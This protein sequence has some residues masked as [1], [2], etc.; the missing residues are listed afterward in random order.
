MSLSPRVAPMLTERAYGLW[1]L[2]LAVM[3]LAWPASAAEPAAGA[4]A[5][6]V[7]EVIFVE[8]AATAQLPGAPPRFLQKGEPLFQGETLNTGGQ[9]FAIIGF[10]DGTKM[11]LRANTTFTIER[12]RHGGTDDS[13]GFRLIKGGLRAVTGL[14][15]KR[16]PKAMQLNAVNATI[17]IRGTTFD[18][19]ICDEECVQEQRRSGDKP[20]VVKEDLVVA[21]AAVV[22][23]SAQAI[24]PAGEARPLAVGSALFTGDTV[25]TQNASQVLIAFRDRSKVTVVANSQFKLENVQFGPKGESGNFV[26]RVLQGGVRALT[27]ILAKNNPKAVNFNVTTV[28][29]GIRGS[30]FDG[31]IGTVCVADGKCGEGVGASVREDGIDMTHGDQTL[32]LGL[33]ESGVLFNNLLVRVPNIHIIFPDVG[34]MLPENTPVDFEA[35]FSSLNIEQLRRGFYI[36]LQGEQGELEF[37][38]RNNTIYLSGGQGAVLPEGEDTVFRTLQNWAVE[39]NRPVVNPTVN[40]AQF[41]GSLIREDKVICEIR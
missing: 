5:K 40:P 23:G 18:A 13:A 29:I 39:L 33:G 28:V 38:A 25:R 27:G 32:T 24:N 4:A 1:L 9:G 3:L 30:A 14:L 36:G 2:W 6:P 35:L 20:P 7:G 31:Y 8:G 22:V 11:T 15:S 26:V 34:A 17:G 21:R 19:R 12:Y 16:D 41:R 10:N 37:I